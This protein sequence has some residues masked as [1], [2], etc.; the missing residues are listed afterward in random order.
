[1][2]RMLGPVIALFRAAEKNP[3]GPEAKMIHSIAQAAN[4][5]EDFISF[6]WPLVTIGL[7]IEDM[8]A[9]LGGL[10]YDNTT[11]VYHADS[12]SVD[13][14]DAMNQGIQRVQASLS[15]IA[16]AARWDATGVFDTPLVTLHNE[17]DSLVPF[18]Q[19]NELKAAVERA[20]NTA[21]L[22]QLTVPPEK[23][24]GKEYPSGLT[25][26]GF[27]ADQ[28]SDAFEKTVNFSAAHDASRT[29]K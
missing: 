6:G 20:H 17:I 12:L 26:C 5:H 1:M 16:A 25:H 8:K 19:E 13:E 3:Q 2:K 27:T 9:T 29:T 28:V 15:A 22:L 23:W 7:G 24:A 10:P 11:K 21:L 18:S 4:V 14:N